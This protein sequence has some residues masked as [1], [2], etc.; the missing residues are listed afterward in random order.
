M[1]C[2]ELLCM[3][4][5][6]F[7]SLAYWPRRHQFSQERTT[8]PGGYPIDGR[9]LVTLPSRCQRAAVCS[10]LL[11]GGF[12]CAGIGR[13]HGLLGLVSGE[14]VSSRR[15]QP[16][17]MTPKNLGRCCCRATLGPYEKSKSRIPLTDDVMTVCQYIS[18]Y[19]SFHHIPS[20]SPAS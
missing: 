19:D 20:S 4:T 9:I 16:A 7:C 15:M 18:A 10:L 11:P 3:S 1:V 8:A 5:G 17:L 2:V 6:N 13:V 14:V 12:F